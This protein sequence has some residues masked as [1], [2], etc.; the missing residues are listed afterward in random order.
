MTTDPREKVFNGGFDNND[1]GGWFAA[2][3]DMSAVGGKLQVQVPGGRRQPYDVIV[4]QNDIRL[5]R[6]AQYTISFTASAG[7]PVTIRT[8]VQLSDEPY[9]ATWS[10]NV[11]LDPSL[12]QYR[13]SFTSNLDTDRGQVSFQLGGSDA[14]WTCTLDDVSLVGG[15][16]AQPYRPDTGSPIRVNQVGYLPSGPKHATVVSDA[17]G[18]LSWQV[19]TSTGAVAASGHSTPRGLDASSGQQVHT[20]D[21][22]S[23][24]TP[25]TGY[26]LRLDGQ[27]SYPFDIAGSLYER[28]RRDALHF[29]Y[30][31]RSG[32]AI[33]NALAPGYS[34][35]AGHVGVPPNQGDT[36]VPCQPGV[37]DYT[38]DVHG[39]WYDAGDQGKYVVNGGIA[40]AQLLSQYERTKTAR[41]V[42]S[43]ALDDGSLS[44]PEHGNHVPDILD[45]ARWELEFLLRMQIP[46]GKPNAGMAHHKVHDRA[47]T[48]LPCLPDQDPQPR[49]L[50][51]PS[52]AATLNLAATAAQAARLYGP[53]DTAF[54]DRCLA[55]ARTAWKAAQDHPGMFARPDDSNGGGPYDDTDVRDEFYWSAAELFITTGEQPYLDA[56]RSSPYWTGDAFHDTGPDWK[57]VAALGRIDLATVPSKLP[58][59]DRDAAR[60]SVSAAADR[61]LKTIQDQAY[62][63]PLGENDYTWGSNSIILNKL[64]VI[65]TAFDLTGE[66]RYRDGVLEGL[67]FILGRNALNQSY[68]TGYGSHFSHNQHS[69]MYAHELDPNL[70]QPPLGSVAGGPNP[71]LEDP[72]AQKALLGTT[73][74]RP[75][76][77]FCYLDDI[78]SWSTNEVAINWNS[79]L[80]W[81][82]SFAADVGAH[83]TPPA[84]VIAA[85]LTGL[86]DDVVITMGEDH[87]VN[88]VLPPGWSVLVQAS[89]GAR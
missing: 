11:G 39:G 66:R 76:P 60:A 10:Q 58:D 81:V 13:Y 31:Q 7:R 52:T 30:L 42:T 59:G 78:Q 2:G 70:P 36:S 54:A 50:H 51:P 57:F 43:A 48:G 34:R 29:F 12:K 56:L 62:G 3:A 40:T 24:S 55:A 77:Q 73:T 45:E 38:L 69:R 21:F 46:A 53:F 1:T 27:R 33:D 22:S 84:P 64:V 86:P 16:A 72:K 6:D 83:D 18:P 85:P 25:G 23:L 82:A 68:V 37:G 47:W 74:E 28:L 67:D 5:E 79:A 32:I 65:A 71:G 89:T 80:S 20:I 17:Q 88:V 4:G 14:A 41:M 87:Q 15:T 9:T 35:P 26:T 8:Q 19:A 75:K 44:I 49:E 61:Y 63:V